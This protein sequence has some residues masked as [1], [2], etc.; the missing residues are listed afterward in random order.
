MKI[1]IV[2]GTTKISSKGDI[3]FHTF[4]GD[5]EFN[6]GQRNIW[7]GEKGNEVGN[8]EEMDTPTPININKHIVEFR[9]PKNFDWSFGF[10]WFREGKDG[11]NGIDFK[12][13]SKNISLLQKEYYAKQLELSQ[14]KN[15]PKDK[16]Y[17]YDS[18]LTIYPPNN[19][20][21]GKN[22]AILSLLTYS[23]EDMKE[24]LKVDYDN[25]CFNVTGQLLPLKKSNKGRLIENALT[26]ECIKTFNE[27]QKIRI[28]TQTNQEVGCLRVL[29][30]G[31][32]HRYKLKIQLIKVFLFEED[33]GYL[34]SQIKQSDIKKMLNTGT[35]SQCYLRPIVEPQVQELDLTDRS[36]EWERYR[37]EIPVK[38]TE[39]KEKIIS[40][41]YLDTV[42]SKIRRAYYDKKADEEYNTNYNLIFFFINHKVGTY[43]ENEGYNKTEQKWGNTKGY[44]NTPGKI[45]LIMQDGV[46]SHTLCHEALHARGL[47][48]TF[49]DEKNT[50]KYLFTKHK[51]DNIMDY[52]E[53]NKNDDR[54]K[55]T[56][57]WQWDKI[58]ELA[59]HENVHIKL[60]KENGYED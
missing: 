40:E 20:K 35:F 7:H 15:K 52:I 53:E 24:P 59:N 1:R 32:S 45:S 2:K 16:E 27:E 48:H 9:P 5:M 55:A 43:Q 29:P 10:D 18:W 21:Y 12:K 38:G 50:S 51:T 19:E 8:Y 57:K 49:E 37:I 44:T 3:V 46:N 30:N 6:A 34:N 14:W 42:Y 28:L 47:D 36:T 31:D 41:T 22:K 13:I 17:S 54:L 33:K 23:D 60:E 26:I 58:K 4:G 11:D 56:Y 25:T 39:Q